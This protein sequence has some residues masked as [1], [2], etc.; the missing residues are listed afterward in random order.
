VPETQRTWDDVATVL[1]YG[2]LI[3]AVVWLLAIRPVR[4]Q[5][6][7]RAAVEARLAPGVRVMTTSGLLGRVVEVA[8]EEVVLDVGNGV[9]LRF[10]ARAVATVLPEDAE[11]IAA[12]PEADTV[13]ALEADTGRPDA[14]QADAGQADAEQ[15]PAGA[16][17]DAPE[18]A[19]N[20][21]PAPNVTDE[22][23]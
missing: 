3:A 13:A 1:V 15:P 20:S 14:G 10:V 21:S 5:R 22:D 8:G 11:T 12:L 23:T 7:Q 16:E 6:A 17:R 2:L 4:R 19:G 18:G 9:Q